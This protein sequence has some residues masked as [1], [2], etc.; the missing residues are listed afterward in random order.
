MNEGLFLLLTHTI[1]IITDMFLNN[2]FCRVKKG[3]EVLIFSMPILF[4]VQMLLDFI[5]CNFHI[6]LSL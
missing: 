3:L 2:D 5:Q 4:K 1:N 6:C